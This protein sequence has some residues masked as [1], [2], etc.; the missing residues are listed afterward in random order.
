MK[1]TNNIKEE[2]KIVDE[3]PTYSVSNLGRLRN[4]ITGNIIKGSFDKDGYRQAIICYKGKQYNRRFCRLVALAFIPNPLNLP[5][6]NHKDENKQN[7][8]TTN[9]EWCTTAY[10]NS[11]GNRTQQTRKRVICVETQ[12]V[13]DGLRVAERLCNVPHSSIS[14]SCRFGIEAGGYHWQYV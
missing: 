7:D 3:F 10:N 9:L 8:T 13:Y 6:V 1:Q 11:Y 14:K 2:W 5:I 12:Q 4:D